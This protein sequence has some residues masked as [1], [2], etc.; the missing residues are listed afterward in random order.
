MTIQLVAC[1]LDGTLVGPDLV[2]SSRVREAVRRA[3][4]QGVTVTLATGRGYPATRPFATQLAIRAP[5]ICYQGAQIR[6]GD[7]S[8]L[9]ETLLPRR[10]LPPVIALCRERGWELSAYCGDRVYQTTQIY[11]PAFYDRWF[12]LP[13][14]QVCGLV[15]ALPGDPIKFIIIAPTQIEGDEIERLL[16]AHADGQ[17]QVM[18]SHPQFVEGLARGVSK[19]DAVARLARQM[20]IERE[21][22]MAIGDSENDRSM[23]AWAGVG[24]AIGNATSEV[25]AVATVIAPAQ[26]QDGAAWAIERYVLGDGA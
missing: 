2:F 4:A 15:K 13:L 25:K 8:T 23:V 24:V 12:G 11:E 14:E 7:G 6:R 3:E 18:R 17:F 26:S 9:Y 5:L 20:G 10:Y 19:G 16:R 22:V 21:E 1:D